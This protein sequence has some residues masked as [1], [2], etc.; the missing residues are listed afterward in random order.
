MG[1]ETTYPMTIGQLSVYRDVQAMPEDRLWEA[2]L[3]PF[4]WDLRQKCTAEQVWDAIGRSPCGTSRCG[5]T[6]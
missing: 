6:T 1:A 5:P 2:N 4:V 3:V